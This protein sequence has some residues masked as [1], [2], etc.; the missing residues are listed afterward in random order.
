MRQVAACASKVEEMGL[1]I[2]D[3]LQPSV[4]GFESGDALEMSALGAE[5]DAHAFVDASSQ[6]AEEH[7]EAYSEELDLTPGEPTETNLMSTYLREMGST[8]LLTREGEV[9]LARRIEHGQMHAIRALSRSPLVWRELA[10][11]ARELR[12]QERALDEFVDCGEQPLA[13][14]ELAEKTRKLLQALDRIAKLQKAA[15]RQQQALQRLARSNGHVFAR[16]RRRYA[17]LTIEI[18]KL[19]R[20]LELHPMEKA[21]LTSKIEEAVAAARTRETA[22]GA[23][24]GRARGIRRPAEPVTDFSGMSARELTRTLETIRRGNA[25]GAQAKKE[26]TEANLRL[27]VSIAK[28]Y[29]NRGLDILDLI[30]EGNMGL[31]KAVDR[32]EWRRGY[33][34]STYATWWIWQSVTRAI[35]GQAR[36]VRLPVHMIETIN[37]LARANR[38]LTKELGRQPVAEEVAKRLGLSVSKVRSLMLT[39]LEPVSLD[40]PVGEDET[41]QF[42]DLIANPKGVLPSETLLL[43][44]MQERTRA[45]LKLLT[46][47]EEKVIR[48]RFGLEDGVEHTL[49]EVG[50]AFGLTRERIR[51]IEAKT[52]R[53][54]RELTPVQELRGYLRRAS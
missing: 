23:G 14:K 53:L 43:S 41:S 40:A 1:T 44:D 10:P 20:S 6:H 51:Q 4:P 36:T 7:A 22:K 50:E 19:I 47:R 34:F 49:S 52:M 18:S 3:E 13:P 39:M 12:R 31:M 17:R 26:L 33:K 11:V 24:R 28:K 9:R 30:Q 2:T 46:P 54:L 37:R 16:A 25:E 48:M 15:L 8:K 5:G 38:E 29:Q 32:F 45:A 21:R 27:V 42:G 35:A